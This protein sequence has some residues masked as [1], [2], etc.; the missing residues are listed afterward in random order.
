VHSPQSFEQQLVKATETQLCATC[1][2]QQ[3]VK[4]ERAVAH[5]PVREGKMSCSSCHNPHGSIANVKALKVGIPS[6]K[7][8]RAVTRDAWADVVRTHAGARE[9]H[10]VPRSARSSNDR[11]LN[12][13]MPMLCQRC[14]V[15]TKHPAVGV[16]QRRHHDEQEQP[17]VRP[18]VRELP[19]EHPRVQPPVGPILHAV[20]KEPG[21]CDHCF[22]EVCAVADARR[23]DSGGRAGPRT[24]LCTCFVASR[25]HDARSDPAP[26]ALAGPLGDDSGSLFGPR[27]NMFQLSDG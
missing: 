26:A 4:T 14:H 1:H 19:L 15:A 17:H 9:L 24:G 16:R 18:I 3:V 6:T 25:R 8:V 21:Q 22:W 23:V 2:R 5:M 10:D 11:M 7:A 20:A 27:W 12:V 13:R